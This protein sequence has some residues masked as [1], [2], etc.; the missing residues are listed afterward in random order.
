MKWILQYASTTVYFWK[1]MGE[2][3]PNLA[4]DTIYCIWGFTCYPLQRNQWIYD[5]LES[6]RTHKHHPVISYKIMSLST[7]DIENIFKQK[8]IMIVGWT[9]FKM[10][11]NLWINEILFNYVWHK[12][13]ILKN[14][15]IQ[16]GRQRTYTVKMCRV[17]IMFTL[18]RLSWYQ[19]SE[20]GRFYGDL[21]TPTTVKVT[22]ICM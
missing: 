14:A 22:E 12:S 10:H 19:F 1:F 15:A 7:A 8:F 5:T 11:Q 2:H 9:L 17:R 3:D 18:P 13:W 20:R 21:G 4:Y 6:I 16:Q